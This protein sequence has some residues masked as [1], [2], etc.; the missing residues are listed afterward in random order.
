MPFLLSLLNLEKTV[1]GPI[2]DLQISNVEIL[3]LDGVEAFSNLHS[4]ALRYCKLDD[5]NRLESCKNLCNSLRLLNI[6]GNKDI[7]SLQPLFSFARMEHLD[8]SYTGLESSEELFWLTRMPRLQCLNLGGL[9]AMV[10]QP[11]FKTRLLY[12]IPLFADN[13]NMQVIF[14]LGADEDA[15][16][17]LNEEFCK[18]Q[19]SVKEGLNP[20]EVYQLRLEIAKLER[21]NDATDEEVV[22]LEKLCAETRRNHMQLS[23]IF[24]TAQA[25]L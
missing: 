6:S 7:K 5:L 22:R 12:A 4:L 20:F 21:E 11:D 1:N 25:Q 10:S 17:Q 15:S 14:N 16:N 13:P 19:L 18:T 2:E 8:C 24:S 9:T 23:S 3:R